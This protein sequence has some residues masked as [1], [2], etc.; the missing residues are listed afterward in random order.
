MVVP[1]ERVPAFVHAQLRLPL[2]K[3]FFQL[4]N[5]KL[6]RIVPL[7]WPSW[8]RSPMCSNWKTI[9]NSSLSGPEYCLAISGVAPQSP[10]P[11]T[12][13][14]PRKSLDSFF[15][16]RWSMGPLATIFWSGIFPIMID[17]IHPKTTDPLVDPKVHHVINLLPKGLIFP[18]QVRLLLTKEVQIILLGSRIKFPSWTTEGRDKIIGLVPPNIVVPLWTVWIFLGFDKPSMLI[19]GMVDHQIHDRF[20]TALLPLRQS[21]FPYLPWCQRWKQYPRNQIYRSH[22]HP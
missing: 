22:Y 19:R 6:L 9:D 15:Q 16:I 13:P 5:I 4:R 8:K 11:L 10:R 12:N 1:K 3:D 17:D 7:G 20:N 18:I 14:Y 21:M 2:V